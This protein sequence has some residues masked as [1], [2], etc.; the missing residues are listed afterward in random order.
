MLARDWLI[1]E[2]PIRDLLLGVYEWLCEVD[3]VDEM[4]DRMEFLQDEA[5]KDPGGELSHAMIYAFMIH[6]H[7]AAVR[8]L[9]PATAAGE[10][11]HLPL[12]TDILRTMKWMLA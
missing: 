10:C 6:P 1:P 4:G 5:N 7:C 3:T 12:S 8:W 9:T 2:M 11:Y